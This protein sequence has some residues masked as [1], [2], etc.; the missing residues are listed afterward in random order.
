MK[1]KNFKS[2]L[3]RKS[4][5]TITVCLGILSTMGTAMAQAPAPAPPAS[6]TSSFSSDS[7]SFRVGTYLKTEN[8]AAFESVPAYIVRFINLLSMAIGSFAFLA[9]VIGGFTMLTSGGREAS[10][11]KGKDII[12]YAI[13][14]L[15]VALA[16]FFITSFVQSIF[17]E[18]TAPK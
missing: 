6:P 16:A 2:G 11:T 4:F 13:L 18:Y 3:L 15:I 14:G 12:K 1:S 8:Q 9:I 10:I 17:Y 7:A 5:A